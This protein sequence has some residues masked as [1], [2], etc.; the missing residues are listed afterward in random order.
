MR[1]CR[2]CCVKIAS[3]I[4][5]IVGVFEGCSRSDSSSNYRTEDDNAERCKFDS[6]H[7]Y[8]PENGARA[9]HNDTVYI[10]LGTKPTDYQLALQVCFR[11]LHYH[12]L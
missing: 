1:W 8:S 11:D 4:R 2:R 3:C 7:G 9:L 10:P 6:D 5:N 12:G